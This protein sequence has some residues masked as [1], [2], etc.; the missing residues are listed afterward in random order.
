MANMLEERFCNCGADIPT[1]ATAAY[2]RALWLVAG[3]NI[4]M[5]V[6]ESVSGYVAG[7]QALK[8]DALDF[9]G[10]G[11]IT[12]LGLIAV[13]WGASP[14]AR[15]A[16]LQGVFLATMGLGVFAFTL[17]RVF[18]TQMP[19][20]MLMGSLGLIAL[21][22]NVACAVI[23]LRY[24]EGDANVRAVWLFSRNDAIGN[25][26]VVIAALVVA[27]TGSPLPDLVTAA[28]IAGLFIHS[29]IR[30]INDSL[31]ELKMTP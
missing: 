11:V 3:L 16:L 24:R 23:L 17:Y 30:I 6:V 8:A 26:A 2:R 13:N 15:A 21:F 25:A 5:G 27:A 31:G 22:V 12:G 19:E 7:S 14:R 9:L 4:F 28:A 10:D 20:A 18:I 1:H 29:A